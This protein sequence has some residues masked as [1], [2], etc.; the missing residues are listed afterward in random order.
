MNNREKFKLDIRENENCKIDKINLIFV[1]TSPTLQ[2]KP[3]VN[4]SHIN[5]EIWALL[6][7]IEDYFSFFKNTNLYFKSLN[8]FRFEYFME[9]MKLELLKNLYN[10][11]DNMPNLK[12]F[13][14]YCDFDG[15]D[16]NLYNALIKKLLSKNL[17]EINLKLKKERTDFYS[18]DEL[19][20]ICPDIGA[21]KLNKIFIRKI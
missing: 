12:V 4:M 11:I 21:A 14:L 18:L 10:N 3:F 6:I 20:K 7:N 16:N 9:K 5:I 19:K 13:I 8:Y 17:D 15:I 2:C 1:D